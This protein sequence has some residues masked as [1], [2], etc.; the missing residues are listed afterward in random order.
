MQSTK[1]VILIVLACVIAINAQSYIGTTVWPDSTCSGTAKGYGG[2]IVPNVCTPS[3]GG[4]VIYA[5]NT[6][7]STSQL[8]CSDAACTT[9]CTVVASS[10]NTC[11]QS[12]VVSGLYLKSFSFF[13]TLPTF[14]NANDGGFASVEILTNCSSSGVVANLLWGK[15]T[16]SSQCVINPF[17]SS[18]S[19]VYVGCSIANQALNV[20]GCGNTT[21]FA[22]VPYACASVGGVSEQATCY[23]TPNATSTTSTSST[24]SGSGGVTSTTSSAVAI[25]AS[26]FVI[27][28][29]IM[30]AAF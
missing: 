4:F 24:G 14:T 21:I 29:A 1:F 25:V 17:N 15:V 5:G 19:A 9:N 7:A 20:F 18:A 30:V 13:S 26:F 3:A 22:S 28:A 11:V 2:N 12:A 16:S 6:T 8:N 10:L 23:Y 27:I